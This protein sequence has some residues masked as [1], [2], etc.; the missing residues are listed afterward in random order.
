MKNRIRLTESQLHR[1][2]KESVNKV[3]T[4]G[5]SNRMKAFKLYMPSDAAFVAEMF[6]GHYDLLTDESLAE[7]ASNISSDI[8]Q[9]SD[10]MEYH[11]FYFK[12]MRELKSR[13]S[14]L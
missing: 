5:Y 3:L 6:D 9:D 13:R 12:I 11:Q 10:N 2:I 1:V 7:I 14:K 8:E 4:E